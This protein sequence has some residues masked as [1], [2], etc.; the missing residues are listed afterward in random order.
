MERAERNQISTSS[1]VSLTLSP[2]TARPIRQ[3]R[4]R[5]VG[6]LPPVKPLCVGSRWGGDSVETLDTA[7]VSQELSQW[8]AVAATCRGD[9]LKFTSVCRA[10]GNGSSGPCDT[11]SE[12]WERSGNV[13]MESQSQTVG[14]TGDFSTRSSLQAAGPRG[15]GQDWNLLHQA[16]HSVLLK[17]HFSP[18]PARFLPER[19]TV[20]LIVLQRSLASLSF[21]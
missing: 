6:G 8:P 15:P 20:T 7:L 21:A 1:R 9:C 4:R 17:G 10:S 19:V 2:G 5:T 16:D 18:Q 11:R 12:G 14:E 13:S 3:R